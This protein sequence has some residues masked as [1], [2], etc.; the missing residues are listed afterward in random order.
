LFVKYLSNEIIL[1]VSAYS[2]ETTRF[3]NGK[4]HGTANRVFEGLLV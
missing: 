2:K 1:Y 4:S 3:I